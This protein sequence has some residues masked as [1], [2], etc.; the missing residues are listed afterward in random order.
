MGKEFPGNARIHQ[1]LPATGRIRQQIVI[2]GTGRLHGT[3][4]NQRH[5][6]LSR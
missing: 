3:D 5:L 4:A 2:T 6:R 1:R